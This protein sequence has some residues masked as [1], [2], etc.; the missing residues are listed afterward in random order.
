MQKRGTRNHNI[1]EHSHT[2][3]SK[4]AFSDRRLFFDESIRLP[5]HNFEDGS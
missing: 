2:K 1:Y 3:I 5:L 4:R